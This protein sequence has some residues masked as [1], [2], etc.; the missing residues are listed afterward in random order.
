MAGPLHATPFEI[1]FVVALV[2]PPG[3]FRLVLVLADWIH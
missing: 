1:V 3:G 2:T